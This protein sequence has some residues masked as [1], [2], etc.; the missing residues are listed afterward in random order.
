MLASSVIKQDFTC[1]CCR[2]SAGRKKP[3]LHIRRRAWKDVYTGLWS[4]FIEL[5]TKSTISLIVGTDKRN[6][7]AG[8]YKKKKNL[9]YNAGLNT[10]AVYQEYR[11]CTILMCPWLQRAGA[12]MQR[13]KNNLMPILACRCKRHDVP[14]TWWKT[15]YLKHSTVAPKIPCAS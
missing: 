4:R 1:C 2:I 14:R 12:N 15:F 13:A 9:L 3:L 5:Q 11:I 10:R 7:E 6:K 8:T